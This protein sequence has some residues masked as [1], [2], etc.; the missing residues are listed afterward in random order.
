MDLGRH[1]I[2][3]QFDTTG[4][5]L[6]G[7]VAKHQDETLWPN[8]TIRGLVNAA[9]QRPQHFDQATGAADHG[10]DGS[11]GAEERLTFDS[12]HVFLSRC[13]PTGDVVGIFECYVK[14]N[15]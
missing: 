14:D 11:M 9:T 5:W 10:G 4:P 12:D 3:R 8:T 15:A 2:Y 7:V 6:Q 13:G 1:V